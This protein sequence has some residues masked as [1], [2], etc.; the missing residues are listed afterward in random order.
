M[1]TA[2]LAT[3]VLFDRLGIP[4]GALLG[5]MIASALLHGTRCP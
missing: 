2:G 5:G 1:L 4:G 3:G